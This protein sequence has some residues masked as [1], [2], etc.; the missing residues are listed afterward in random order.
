MGKKDQPSKISLRRSLFPNVPPYI[1]FSSVVLT[2]SLP[3]VRSHQTRPAAPTL[4]H[5]SLQTLAV[6]APEGLDQ[7]YSLNECLILA[8]LDIK[9]VR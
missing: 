4:K 5:N 1:H 2:D 9:Q 8:G 7:F 3:T 6:T